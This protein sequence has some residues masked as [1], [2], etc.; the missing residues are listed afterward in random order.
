MNFCIPSKIF[1]ER[2]CWMEN[3]QKRPVN[4]LTSLRF[5]VF[6]QMSMKTAVF[7]DVVPCTSVDIYRRF[8][9]AYCLHDQVS[10]DCTA[11]H[12]RRRPFANELPS[13]IK[14]SRWIYV[15]KSVTQSGPISWWNTVVMV[16]LM[17][18]NLR[19]LTQDSIPDQRNLVCRLLINTVIVY[20]WLALPSHLLLGISE[21]TLPKHC[22]ASSHSNPLTHFSRAACSS[23]WWWKQ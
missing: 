3:E 4:K 18:W 21:W 20:V 14:N 23:P 10:H 19:L 12:P 6:V 5:L 2:C 7:W 16:M 22:P 17:R 8:E 9:G 1:L 15:V 13:N 11:Q